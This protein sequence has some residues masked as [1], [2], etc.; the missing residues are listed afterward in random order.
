VKE[1]FTTNPQEVSDLSW[2]WLLSHTMRRNTAEKIGNLNQ[3]EA[4]NTP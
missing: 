2:G 3:Q 4:F 1:K